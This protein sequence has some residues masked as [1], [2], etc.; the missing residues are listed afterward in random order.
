M[1]E[2]GNQE[3]TQTASEIEAQQFGWVP[4]EEFKGDESQWRDADEF[5]RRGQEI[6]GFLRKDLEKIRGKNTVLE[7]ELQAVRQAVSEFKEFHEKTEQRAYDKALAELKAQKK[8]AIREQDGD[9]VVEIDDAIDELK[10][11]RTT[12]KPEVKTNEAV[13]QQ[14]F[15]EWSAE[16]PWFSKDKSLQAASNGYADIVKAEN[17]TLV[18]REFLDA[19]AEKVKEAFP[20]KFQ[21]TSRERPMAV[22][23]AQS[24][25]RSNSTKKSYA[26]LPADV[27][28]Q[29][30][31]FVGQKLL[32]REQYVKDYFEQ[33]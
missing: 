5:L 14:Q 30:D 8:E 15:V 18:G 1:S 4:K 9:T 27:K 20:E 29:C 6:N 16:N 13:Y 33:E 26:D 7:R 10:A 2:E 28:A 23:G 22:E 21:N 24:T 25:P 19:V 17:P 11:S 31:I 32:T 3:V 12:P